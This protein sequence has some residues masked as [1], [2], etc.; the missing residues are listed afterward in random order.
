[1]K[2][3]LLTTAVLQ[4][5]KKRNMTR[6]ESFRL[7]A[8]RNIVTHH[9]HQRRVEIKDHPPKMKSHQ[10]NMTTNGRET[11][12]LHRG[13]DLASQATVRNIPTL[14]PTDNTTVINATNSVDVHQRGTVQVHERDPST[15]LLN[16]QA[17]TDQLQ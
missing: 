8:E 13:K 6:Q 2:S 16:Q 15:S 7:Q 10:Q 12:H 5:E 14:I 1:M 9:R 3:T 17:T 11:T 4:T